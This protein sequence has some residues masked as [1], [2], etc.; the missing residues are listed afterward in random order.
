MGWKVF[1][2]IIDNEKRVDYENIL[3]DIGYSE[4]TKTEDMFFETA[5]YPDQNKVY[6]GNY[7]DKILICEYYLPYYIIK[8]HDSG[9][10]NY[11]QNLFPNSEIPSM[12]LESV[13]NAW[14]YSVFK[15]NKMKR[16]RLGDYDDGT[17]IDIGGPIEEEIELL[18]KSKLND[19][20]QRLYYL[21]KY[22]GDP[23]REDQV[24]ELLVAA[25]SKR[26]LGEGIDCLDNTLSDTKLAGY[27]YK[28]FLDKAKIKKEKEAKEKAERDR[29]E[30]REKK[31]RKIFLIIVGIIITIEGLVKL[32]QKIF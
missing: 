17:T 15:T 26:Y 7:K 10:V 3:N 8:N 14:G 27:N 31:H 4:L 24:G 9:L 22:K 5:L 1:L 16:I 29:K 12:I 28:Y 2:L 13:V 25:I 11:L 18:S 6:I 20:G 21:E 23:L 30:K 32:I 19:E